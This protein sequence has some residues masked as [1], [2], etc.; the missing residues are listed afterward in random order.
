MAASQDTRGPPRLDHTH[1]VALEVRSRGRGRAVRA[2]AGGVLAGGRAK[3]CRRRGAAAGRSVGRRARLFNAA[4]VLTVARGVGCLLV[5]LL[6]TTLAAGW[7]LVT[8]DLLS[9]NLQHPV[10]WPDYVTIAWLASSI[11]TVGGAL[12]GGPR[13]PLWS[14]GAVPC[15]RQAH[16]AAATPPSSVWAGSVLWRS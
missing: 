16:P 12:G 5:A 15:R 9:Q 13:R 14:S 4:T 7:F 10:G 1:L 11:A 3:L 8:G 2:V 6:L